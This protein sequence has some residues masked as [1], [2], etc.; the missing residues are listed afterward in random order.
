MES[1]ELC[2]TSDELKGAALCQ[3]KLRLEE[4]EMHSFRLLVRIFL[5]RESHIL[6][7][8][9]RYPSAKYRHLLSW[10]DWRWDTDMEKMWLS[11]K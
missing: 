8:D 4:T 2:H 5:L 1:W 7:M 10:E 9:H 11:T 6:E 3:G